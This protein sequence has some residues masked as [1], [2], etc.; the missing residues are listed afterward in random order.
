MSLD[1]P[2]PVVL[3]LAVPPAFGHLYHF[4][5]IINV[6]SGLGL[7]ETVMDRMRL[8]IVLGLGISSAV[9]I[10]MH[11]RAPWWTWHGPLWAYAALCVVSGMLTWPLCS[12]RIATR[13]RPDG[14]AG[15]STILDLKGSPE[16]SSLVGRGHDSWMLRLPGNESLSL[17]LREWD[18][19]IASLPEPLE[20]L[21]IIQ[22]SDLHFAPCYDRR[23]FELVVDACRAWDADLVFVTG[24]LVDHDETIGWIEPILSPL[25]ARLGKYAILGNHDKDHQPG[26][27]A[28]ELGRAGFEM[29]EGVWTTVE[30]DGAT[31]ALGGTSAPWGPDV[32]PSATPPADF[33]I[34]LSHSP[35]RFYRA[36]RWGMDLMF[37]GHNHGGQIRL[38]LVGAVFMP[39][40]YSR[41]FDRGF[42]RRGATLLY[43]SEGVGGKHPVRYGCPPEV[44]RF[45]LRTATGPR[46][47]D[48]KSVPKSVPLWKGKALERDWV[49]G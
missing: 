33:R 11:M 35:D 30:R 2:W 48:D 18:L 27:I 20:G 49:Q 47:L 32:D 17:C 12:L 37:S 31:I 40:I 46:R 28:G 42:F 9:L 25:E 19:S 38:P 8:L 45:V 39:S 26:A 13:R 15:S 3:A 41:R 43:V 21:R 16:V 29:L 36:A 22:I 34:L 4:I 7:R 5:L 23:Y 6:G 14:I 24:D 1:W 10:W 44:S